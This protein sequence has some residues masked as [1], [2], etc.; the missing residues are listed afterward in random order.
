MKKLLKLLTAGLMIG[1]VAFGVSQLKK[2]DSVRVEGSPLTKRVWMKNSITESWD[3]D[4]AATAI[5]YWGGSQG[6]TYPGVLVRWDNNN[7]KCYYDLPN[8]VT[9]YM[10]T[11]V[12]GDGKEYWGAETNDL[13]YDDS[14]GK[15]Y[16]LSGP[17]A[18]DGAKTPGSLVS[19]A[20]V[21][22]EVVADFAATI[23]T[24][25]E[26]CSASAAQTAINNFNNLATFEQN[27]YKALD[28]GGGKTGLDRL[29]Y[30]KARYNIDTPIG[31]SPIRNTNANSDSTTL[32]A[33]VTITALGFLAL[34]GY[35]FLKK[36]VN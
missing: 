19:F 34:G 8:D 16:D 24:A 36:K 27:Q 2:Q 14:V 32:F 25:T 13:S 10:F 9:H 20:P 15:Y 23:D 4:G 6:T 17:I 28:V 1:A 7:Q 31:G 18:W 5:H 21:T 33:I 12:S 35:F 26:A 22:T 30:L 3:K 11:R 29:N